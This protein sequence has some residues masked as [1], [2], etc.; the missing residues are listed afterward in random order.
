MSA[1]RGG[2]CAPAGRLSDATD[3]GGLARV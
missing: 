2:R 1:V 3:R